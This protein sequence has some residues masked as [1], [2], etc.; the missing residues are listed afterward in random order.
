MTEPFHAGL[1]ALY[2]R[3]GWK[4][5]LIEGASA[6]GKSDLALRCLSLGFRLVADDRTRLWIAEGRLFG[7][8][9]EPIAGLIELRG[10]GVLPESAR[11]F[12]QVRLVVRCLAASE[13]LDRYP[14][15]D[16]RTLIG[17]TLPKVAVRPL[18]ASAP[19]KLLRA[20]SLLGGAG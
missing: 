5:V 6:A 7:A 9:P 17:I 3:G 10:L 1:I 14:D 18:E 16:T 13:P 15:P 11:T 20:L 2:D 19:Q 8:A 12:A 4:G